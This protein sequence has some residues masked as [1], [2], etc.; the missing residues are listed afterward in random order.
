MR[1][2]EGGG[3]VGGGVLGG[4]EGGVRGFVTGV[5]EK[6]GR[7]DRD[8]RKRMLAR[9]GAR[10]FTSLFLL[11]LVHVPLFM[12]HVFTSLCS[13]PSLHVP[14]FVHVPL[15]ISCR[16]YLEEAPAG[17]VRAQEGCCCCGPAAA[18]TGLQCQQGL[19][20][21]RIWGQHRHSS[22]NKGGH[23][24]LAWSS[25]GKDTRWVVGVACFVVCVVGGGG[26]GVSVALGEGASCVL[27]SGRKRRGRVICHMGE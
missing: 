10:P 26:G 13:C 19:H 16:V 12:S 24:H 14:I 27:R 1:G 15:V 4:S 5:Q 9:R 2:G 6:G 23:Q 7:G 18:H 20:G 11:S 25:A 21:R 22:S 8:K 3:G 17:Q